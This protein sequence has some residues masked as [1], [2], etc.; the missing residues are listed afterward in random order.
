MIYEIKTF[1]D[2]KARIFYDL[3]LDGLILFRAKK[4]GFEG[5]N[6]SVSVVEKV[7]T[8]VTPPQEPENPEDPPGEPTTEMTIE[9]YTISAS[10]RGIVEFTF[11]RNADLAFNPILLN[12][13]YELD[14]ICIFSDGVFSVSPLDIELS[15]GKP[16]KNDDLV[17]SIP[18]HE[19]QDG[20]IFKF[21]INCLPLMK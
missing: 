5:N 7:R 1:N 4:S 21:S 13:D 15:P 17:F 18:Q 2:F 9:E 16:F 20:D 6:I 12:K 8:T 19:Y 10:Q 14:A 3:S 11:S